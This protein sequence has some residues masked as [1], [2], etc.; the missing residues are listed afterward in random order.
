M[1]LVFVL[2]VITRSCCL[3]VAFYL[4]CWLVLLTVD[5]W[6]VVLCSLLASCVACDCRFGSCALHLVCSLVVMVFL[7]V[8]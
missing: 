7:I 4:R 6:L 2:L 3:L 1:C 8:L 5:L